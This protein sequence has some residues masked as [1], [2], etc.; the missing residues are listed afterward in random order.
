MAGTSNIVLTARSQSELESAREEI[1]SEPQLG[2]SPNVIVQVTDVTSEESVKALF[3]KLD[4]ESINIDVLVNNAGM[5]IIPA[6]IASLLSSLQSYNRLLG[7]VGLDPRI[8]SK[9]VVDDL[10]SEHQ[11]D[12]SSYPFPVEEDLLLQCRC[13]EPCDYYLHNVRL[14]LHSNNVSF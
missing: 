12:L 7:E 5:N 11:G 10:G 6:S 3:D 4:Q 2:E 1:L 13:T 9:R 14:L 8:R